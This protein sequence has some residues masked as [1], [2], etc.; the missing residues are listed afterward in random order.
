MVADSIAAGI[1]S[2]TLTVRT[3]STWMN[4]G[5]EAD[6]SSLQDAIVGAAAKVEQGDLSGAEAMLLAQAMSLNAMFAKF[7]QHAHVAEYVAQ[8][9]Q[10]ARLALKA[11]SQCRATVE[12]LA[13]IK[14]PPVFARHAN[15]AGGSQLVNNGVVNNGVTRAGIQESAPNKLLEAHGDRMD[16]GQAEA[17]V[18]SN[19]SVEAVEALDG[20]AH[21]AG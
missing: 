3:W 11:Q 13:L 2:N 9:D 12:T 20:A 21:T 14:N 15:I 10:Y 19:P 18:G 8:V 1:V 4:G 5:T 6:F 17:T 16:S 7:A